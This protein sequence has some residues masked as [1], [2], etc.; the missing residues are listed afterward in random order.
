MKSLSGE[1]ARPVRG[2]RMAQ[3]DL[4]EAEAEVEAR[5]WKK[6]NSDIALQ[7]TN[8]EFESQTISAT[9]SKS[10]VRSGSKRE[11]QLVWRIGIEK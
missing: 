2:E 3:Q 4:Y 5:Y 1:L 7:E 6:R 9:A 10:I 8:Q 11:H